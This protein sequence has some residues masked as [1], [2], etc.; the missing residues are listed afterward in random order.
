[1]FVFNKE[2]KGYFYNM[3]VDTSTNKI[4]VGFF[5]SIPL[6]DIGGFYEHVNILTEQQKIF[7]SL[8]ND[9]FQSP[10]N[11]IIVISGSPGSGKTFTVNETL[12]YIDTHI[13]KM[14]YTAKTACNIGGSTIHSTLHLNWDESS[15]L[16]KL[17]SDIQ[18]LDDDDKDYK[19]KCLN[20][21]EML[22]KHLNCLTNPRIIVIDEIGMISFWL[23]NEIV[24]YFFSFTSDPKLIIMMGDEFQLR[25]V[26]CKYNIF[27]M[28]SFEFK[29]VELNDNKRFSEDYN[30][31][32]NQLKDFMRQD[33]E[34][35]FFAYI[36]S[37]FPILENI[38]DYQLKE[39]N[40]VLVYT[41]E[42]AKKY[43]NFYIE[44]LPGPKIC[45]PEIKNNHISQTNFINLKRN[46]DV[47]A[48]RNCIVPNGTLLKFIDYDSDNDLLI[49]KNPN[50][51]NLVRMR[52]DDYTGNF[53]ITV[54]FATTIHKFQGQTINEPNILM[55]FDQC[56]DLHLI[57][58]ALSRVRSMNQIIGVIL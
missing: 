26:D 29:L 34:D 52:R 37:K 41:N 39:C 45:F 51:C 47:V 48:T 20:L 10:S 4:P 35:E 19:E 44:N 3:A 14:A 30:I 33:N 18:K 17:I 8:L 2:N 15:F 11:D 5:K 6:L 24:N 25:P 16:Y 55:E 1:M 7:P 40:R 46:C 50:R 42:T 31:I 13:L 43:N 53:P 57:Y 9:W 56:K 28:K 21:S 58:T 49:C 23:T 12:M 36:N 38:Y 32:I 22:Q 54:G 27:N